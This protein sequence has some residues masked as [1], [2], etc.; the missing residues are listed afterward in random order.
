MDKLLRERKKSYR[1]RYSDGC[2][3]TLKGKTSK[4]ATIFD[5][6]LG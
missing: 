5:V 3:N 4:T 2:G 6:S 1:K